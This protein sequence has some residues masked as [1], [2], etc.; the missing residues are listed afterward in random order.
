MNEHWFGRI[1]S[2][3]A[4]RQFTVRDHGRASRMEQ[5]RAMRRLKKER[6]NF[7]EQERQRRL[8]EDRPGSCPADGFKDFQNFRQL[9]G[10][11]LNTAAQIFS[12]CCNGFSTESAVDL[13]KGGKD[14]GVHAGPC[15]QGDSD[16]EEDADYGANDAG[17]GPLDSL[18]QPQYRP[19]HTDGE[20]ND[21]DL[22]MQHHGSVVL[23]GLDKQAEKVGDDAPLDDGVGAT[24]P[25]EQPGE[26]PPE[27]YGGVAPEPKAKRQ[28]RKKTSAD[29]KRYSEV[30]MD[31][32]LDAAAAS[33][34]EDVTDQ[35]SLAVV[36][37]TVELRFIRNPRAALRKAVMPSTW[38][39]YQ[40]QAAHRLDQECLRHHPTATRLSMW[41]EKAEKAVEHIR[42][43]CKHIIAPKA[44]LPLYAPKQ[45]WPV[46]AHTSEIARPAQCLAWGDEKA[47]HVGAVMA[48]WVL[49]RGRKSGGQSHAKKFYGVGLSEYI[50]TPQLQVVEFHREELADKTWFMRAGKFSPEV[51]ISTTQVI[52]QFEGQQY[53]RGGALEL[54]CNRLTSDV[55]SEAF[56][57]P[58]AVIERMEPEKEEVIREQAEPKARKKKSRARD[59]AEDADD[60]EGEWGEE[61]GDDEA[62]GGVAPARVARTK[63]PTGT[64]ASKS[65]P[66]KPKISTEAPRNFESKDF[67]KFAKGKANIEDAVQRIV[68]KFA[69]AGCPIVDSG[70]HV[71]DAGINT[72]AKGG[73]AEVR[74][75]LDMKGNKVSV[76]DLQKRAVLYFE[77]T[78]KEKTGESYG[79]AVANK[80]WDAASSVKKAVQL[81][82]F[83]I[84]GTVAPK[85]ASTLKIAI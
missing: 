60:A 15:D 80:V 10:S 68:R 81:F 38:N 70:G 36:E 44:D 52:A 14:L 19:V 85:Q 30:L 59:E 69:R 6:K 39:E 34:L 23:E 57:N 2:N 26:D 54:R 17:D 71:T 41:M 62:Y 35:L 28:R 66:W 61:E 27:A 76:I 33:R 51:T 42:E 83:I 43:R 1:R 8:A 75:I 40:A 63:A 46:G 73:K 79:R 21:Q 32:V 65:T 64:S 74:A 55:L 58:G 22:V 67:T 50:R 16:E 3:F 82:G 12:L 9:D 20:P 13:V 53:W 78:E 45:F 18:G 11:A 77:R 24:G 56:L 25:G 4:T 72:H 49:K 84:R 37:T 47:V 48:T 7:T 31:A 5:R 29:T